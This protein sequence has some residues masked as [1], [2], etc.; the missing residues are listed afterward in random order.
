MMWTIIRQ[1]VLQR[2][3]NRC[4]S[5]GKSNTLLHIHHKIPK[6]CGGN[7]ELD[8]LITLCRDCHKVIEAAFNPSQNRI[9]G[10]IRL[11]LSMKLLSE[12]RH[13]AIVEKTTVED[14]AINAITKHYI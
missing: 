9:Y 3:S 11:K 1:Q 13:L 10:T 4:K 6:S 5:C 7:D 12:L 14:L 2:D 8:N